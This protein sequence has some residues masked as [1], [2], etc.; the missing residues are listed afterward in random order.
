[1]PESVFLTRERSGGIA[2]TALLLSLL[3]HAAILGTVGPL[4][5]RGR[6]VLASQAKEMARTFH[7]RQAELPNSL[8][9]ARAQSST[10]TM[11]PVPE[12]EV[13]KEM[14]GAEAIVQKLAQENPVRVPLPETAPGGAPEVAVLAPTP[15]S[16]TSPYL[17]DLR[18]EVENATSQTNVGPAVPGV[19]ND[20]IVLPSGVGPN[21]R[22]G[23]SAAGQAGTH[24]DQAAGGAGLP[25]ADDV[26]SQFRAAANFDPRIPQPI[27]VRLPSD[28]LFD[29][30]SYELRPDA[31]PLLAQVAEILKRYGRA[32]VEIGGHTD[33][34]G[35]DQYNLKLSQ[36]RAEAVRR[37]FEERLPG[38]QLS[39]H[40]TGYGRLK[41]IVNPRGTIEEQAKNRRVEIVIRA[42]PP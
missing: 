1:M 37:W 22:A 20:T 2:L 25:G 38:E 7:L 3:V 33:T 26:Q 14:K 6:M 8:F 41:P 10:P 13:P 23:A 28:I 11:A 18:A 30:D 32:E 16:E 31:E 34:F 29:F 36:E 39:F 19:P 9:Q 5:V 15:P 24:P 12:L 21:A 35:D 40:A 17:P 27:M 4:R 42:I